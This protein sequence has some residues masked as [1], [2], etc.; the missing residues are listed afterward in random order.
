MKKKLWKFVNIDV[1]WNEKEEDKKQIKEI[2]FDIDNSIY[3]QIKKYY[4]NNSIKLLCDLYKNNISINFESIYSIL[5][6]DIYY[7]KISSDKIKI[8]KEK[9]TNSL[10]F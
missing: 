5:I 8:L 10:F 9:K 7:N 6:D 3:K 2:N 4:Q 1:S